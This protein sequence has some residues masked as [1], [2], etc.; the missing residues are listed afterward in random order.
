M[1]ASKRLSQV[2]ENAKI[3]PFDDNSR[4]V[5]MSDCHRGN[6]SWGDNFSSN[7][8]LY[9][10]ALRYYYDNGYSYIELGDGDELWENR[11]IEDIINAHSDAFWLM[12]LFH[13]SKR[14]YMLYGN[15]D[16]IKKDPRFLQ[17]KC[18]EFY[19]DGIMSQMA[20]FPGIEITEGLIL[21]NKKSRIQLFLTHGHQGDLL[22]DRFWKLSRF[23][24]RYLWRPLELIGVKDPTS[25]AKNNEK[26]NSV[27]R[28]LMEWSLE[29]NQILICGHTHRPVFPKVGETLYFNDGSCVHPRCI[30][31]I[32]IK[33]N[34]ISLV[35]WA[36]MTK[37]DRTL[38]VGREVLEGPI[39]LVD[40]LSVDTTS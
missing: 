20:L 3:V 17:T 26:K 36:V 25:A 28:K 40:Y 2:Y 35:K 8:N 11:R 15:H 38:Y 14:F 16:I 9:F 22:N 34:T 39:R 1:S 7:Q 27:E 19:C 13:K 12:S 33:Y 24:V 10:A 23:L 29:Y 31:A 6:G 30:T 4:I 5:I 21:R 37:P 18:N 32:E